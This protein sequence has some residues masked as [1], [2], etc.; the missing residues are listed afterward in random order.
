MGKHR[1]EDTEDT[2]GEDLRVAGV[3]GSLVNTVAPGRE[4]LNGKASHGGH[5][6][7]NWESS[8]ILQLLNSCN[9]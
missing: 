2:E 7:G 1:T 3:E 6:G 8:L 4:H 5:G 9:S